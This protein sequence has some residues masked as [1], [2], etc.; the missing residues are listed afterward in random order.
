MNSKDFET[1]TRRNTTKILLC[2]VA[3]VALSVL[4]VMFFM[5]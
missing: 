1:K 3:M 5:I 2:D 4:I